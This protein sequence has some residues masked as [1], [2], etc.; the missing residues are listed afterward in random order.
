MS[1]QETILIEYIGRGS[2]CQHAIVGGVRKGKPFECSREIFEKLDKS[3]FRIAGEPT[4]EPP[5]RLE[6]LEN[7]E[8]GGE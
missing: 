2:G 7:E 4:S 1:A 3:M 8:E 6:T 5:E